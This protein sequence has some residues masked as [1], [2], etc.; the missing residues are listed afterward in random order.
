MIR[1]RIDSWDHKNPEEPIGFIKSYRDKSLKESS[2]HESVTRW[3]LPLSGPPDEFDPNYVGMTD[4]DFNTGHIRKAAIYDASSRV[5][6]DLATD[7]DIL[8]RLKEFI[9]WIENEIH[10][11]GKNI[12]PF[13]VDLNANSGGDESRN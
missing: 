11:M 1:S 6:P 5:R 7:D 10:E 3:I 8:M 4:C 9:E 13:L 2:S 12:R